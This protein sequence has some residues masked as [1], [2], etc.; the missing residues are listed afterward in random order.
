[1]YSPHR[2]IPISSQSLSSSTT[3]R[4]SPASTKL[5]HSQQ[6]LKSPSSSSSSTPKCSLW[7]LVIPITFI[8]LGIILPFMI[9][10]FNDPLDAQ[11][12]NNNEPVIK[13]TT[14][15]R[16]MQLASSSFGASK[17]KRLWI[18]IYIP[19][20]YVYINIYTLIS[21]KNKSFL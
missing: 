2:T 13:R 19:V 7:L 14:F 17:G 11:S 4:F 12:K 6:N 5:K 1:M 16:F 9:L 20:L 21:S 8:T 15:D 18:Y 3:S 10:T